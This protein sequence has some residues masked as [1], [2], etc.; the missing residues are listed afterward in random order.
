MRAKNF[1][2]VKNLRISE[3][4]WKMLLFIV[5]KIEVVISKQLLPLKASF[6]VRIKK[7]STPSVKYASEQLTKFK[8][9]LICFESIIL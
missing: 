6:L 7:I 9:E 5:V 8:K 3:S 2:M 4:A 1:E